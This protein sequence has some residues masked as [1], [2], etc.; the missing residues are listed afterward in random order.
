MNTKSLIAII[1]ALVCLTAGAVALTSVQDEN[2]DGATSEFS[3][4]IEA[5]KNYSNHSIYV[6][7]NRYANFG[8]FGPE[9]QFPPGISFSTKIV[10][11][12]MNIVV[13]GSTNWVGSTQLYYYENILYQKYFTI[14]VT[15]GNA[16]VTYHAGM[17][18]INGSSTWSETIALNEYA[19]LPN[20]TYSSG[21]YTFKGWATT[22]TSSTPVTNYKVTGNADL[23]AVWE[24]NST[25]IS[26]YSATI[27]NGQSFSN[28][29]T[30]T[31]SNASVSI[32][33]NGGLS[34]LSISGRTLSGTIN[35]DPGTYNITL[36]V[37]ASGYKT[38]TKTVTITVPIEIVEP[39]QYTL[40]V[41]FDFTYEPVTNPRNAKIT[42]TGVTLGGATYNG[43]NFTVDGRTIKG[44]LT[45]TGTV[46]ISF[47]ASGSGYVSVNKTVLISVYDPPVT[48]EPA[49]ISDF[50][51]VQRAF[52]PRTFDF[53]AV[54]VANA[55]NIEWYVDGILFASSHNTA[56]FEVPTS[57]KYT[58][59]VKVYGADGST[60][61]VSKEFICIETYHPELAWVGVKY[62]HALEYGI[63]VTENADWLDV[64]TYTINGQQC[65][66]VTGTP[67]ASHVGNSYI[68]DLS[69]GDDIEVTVYNAETSAPISSFDV[70]VTDQRVAVTFTGSGA[71]V[72]YYDYNDGTPLTTA[73][74]HDYAD[75]GYYSIRA[76]AVNN[77][78]ERVSVKTVE[79]GI[80]EVTTISLNDL[81]DMYVLV[82]ETI[83]LQIEMADDDVLTASG[84]ASQWLSVSD[85]DVNRVIGAIDR[86]GDFSLI[87]TLTH[88][89]GT[90]S[91]GSITI[92]VRNA[93]PGPTPN[94]VDPDDLLKLEYIIIALILLL[95]IVAIAVLV[96]KKNK[97]KSKSKGGKKK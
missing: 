50:N 79:V 48:S 18:L 26:S 53:V 38:T 27:T 6:P 7:S 77:I 67:A 87:L 73:T 71:S 9:G 5:G 68:L 42:I 15:P 82:G 81:T 24:Q 44:Q 45:H 74:T 64:E 11:D 52:E 90:T 36:S 2:V 65:Y 96:K 4:T 93:D 47:S 55:V 51:I 80:V 54:G 23:Y 21:A 86:A 13:N 46:A 39:I 3:A 8:G 25:S 31:P 61:E 63:T 92:Y 28:T 16:T 62:V 57:G 70:I 72:V 94:P 60:D 41:G 43:H 35:A 91:T 17:G 30:T 12:V 49:T 10:N 34:G 66:V 37:S 14:T 85:T 32:A 20:A 69:S 75:P 58:A 78:S 89:D 1:L 97:S 95:I 84:T 40:P 29:F 19:T 33:S 22:S 56:V 59:K 83:V 88:A 76:I